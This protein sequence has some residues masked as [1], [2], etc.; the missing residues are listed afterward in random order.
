MTKRPQY[1]ARRKYS[2][3]NKALLRRH[4]CTG[5]ASSPAGCSVTNCS[6]DSVDA[7]V[8]VPHLILLSLC[9][10]CVVSFMYVIVHLMCRILFFI[11]L[12]MSTTNFYLVNKRLRE[13]GRERVEV[14]IC[15]VI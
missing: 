1:G 14:E 7:D 15:A 8:F 10:D 6:N 5:H 3:S 4:Q 13:R 12:S 2:V 11:Y 9:G